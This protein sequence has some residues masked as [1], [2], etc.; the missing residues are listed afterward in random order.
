MA[1]TWCK[2]NMG[3]N[4]RKH[5]LPA[6]YF[7]DWHDDPKI[8][9]EYDDTSNEI[10]IFWKNCIDV[11]ELLTTLIHEWQHQLQPLR[12]Q[13]FKYKGTYYQN[14]FEKEARWAEKEYLT[15][16]WDALKPKV[17]KN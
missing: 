5:W 8:C 14:P 11:R 12:T 7:T 13:Y 9:G 15:P 16:L 1:T 3:V 2:R 17:N 4:N 6:V 10:F